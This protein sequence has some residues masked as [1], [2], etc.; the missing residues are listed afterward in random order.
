MSDESIRD[1]DHIVCSII[2][3]I[4]VRKIRLQKSSLDKKFKIVK[5]QIDL[6]GIIDYN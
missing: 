1:G 4:K 2:G 5:I 3:K 6:K